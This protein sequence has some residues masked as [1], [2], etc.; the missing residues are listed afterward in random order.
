MLCTWWIIHCELLE[1]N[2]TVSAKRYCQQ[3]RRLEEAIQ[4][5]DDME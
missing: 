3:L 1:T 2:L 4:R 5:A